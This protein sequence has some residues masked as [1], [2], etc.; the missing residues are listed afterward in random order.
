VLPCTVS[1]GKPILIRRLCGRPPF[2]S[3]NQRKLF[4]QIQ[5]EPVRFRADYGWS[6]VSKEAKDLIEKMLAKD[7][8]ER[9]T[10]AAILE[11]PWLV[12]KHTYSGNDLKAS[13]S[14]LTQY[15]DGSLQGDD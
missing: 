9:I 11:Q 14:Q 10:A 8:A 13:T 1:S 4:E 15:L 5:R 6:S 2:W 7:P 3:R 12:E